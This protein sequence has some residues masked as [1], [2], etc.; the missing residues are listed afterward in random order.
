MKKLIVTVTLALSLSPIL[1]SATTALE[2]LIPERIQAG[3][4]GIPPIANFCTCFLSQASATCTSSGKFPPSM[5][6]QSAILASMKAV[7]DFSGFCAKY[8]SMGLI[9]PGVNQ[10]ECVIDIR[11]VHDHC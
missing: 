2:N 11:Y 5:C 6:Q 9:P 3:V 10:A 8:S 1:S 4:C 7:S